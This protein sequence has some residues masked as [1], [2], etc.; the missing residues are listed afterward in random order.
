MEVIPIQ[1]TH[2]LQEGP[3]II[4][5]WKGESETILGWIVLCQ[6]LDLK[7]KTFLFLLSSSLRCWLRIS[8]LEIGSF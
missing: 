2:S 6:F 3:R 7:A 8:H 4:C 5:G 1:I